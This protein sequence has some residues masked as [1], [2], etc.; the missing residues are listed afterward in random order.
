MSVFFRCYVCSILLIL[1]IPALFAQNC[2]TTPAFEVWVEQD[3]P[4]GQVEAYC[5]LSQNLSM[6]IY[7]PV[8]DGNLLRPAVV[9]IHGGAFLTG[10]KGSYDVAEAARAFASRGYLAVSINYRL[11]F[12]KSVFY[13]NE[14]TNCAL[15][16]ALAGINNPQCLYAYDKEVVR[17]LCRGV[18]DAR[19]AIRFVKNQIDSVDVDNV[20][21]GGSSAG[22]FIALAVG[23]MGEDEWPADAGALPDIYGGIPF[24]YW[25]CHANGAL[26]SLERPALGPAQGELN[27]GGN[28]ASVKG[29]LNIFGG[30]LSL[31]WIDEGEPPLYAYHQDN[32]LVS[33]CTQGKPFDA[34]LAQ[35]VLNACSAIPNTWPASYGSCAIQEYLDT[36]ANAPAHEVWID[37]CPLP[38]FPCSYS[39]HEVTMASVNQIV[40]NAAQFWSCLICPPGPGGCVLVGTAG[41]TRNSA[42]AISLAP[43]PVRGELRV[44]LPEGR[45]IWRV[46][47]FNLAG[48]CVLRTLLSG[49]TTLDIGELSPGFYL[50]RLEHGESAIT[51]KIVVRW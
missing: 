8:G 14:A 22:G 34:T 44:T 6:D 51:R 32:D 5:G 27:L 39:C 40:A 1:G 12:H 30:L 49:S 29:V 2:Y 41:H 31:G 37:N 33:P 36:L 17:S 13:A 20:F 9:L 3:V 46:A 26:C 47:F 15:L 50:V 10:D 16:G 25:G 28:D 43:N 42:E 11:G 35:C 7:R 21:V 19:G 48:Q 45:D 4:Y 24:A 18:Q 38:S 23:Y